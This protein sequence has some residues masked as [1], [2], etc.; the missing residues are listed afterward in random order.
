MN[1]KP[2]QL[3]QNGYVLLDSLEHKAL[4]PFIQIY[5]KKKTFAVIF[6]WAAN[7]LIFLIILLRLY[8]FYQPEKFKFGDAIGHLSY[9]FA[10]AFC[11]IPIHEYIHVLAYKS[12][13]AKTTSY[14]VNLKKFYFMAIADKFVANRKEFTVVALAPFVLI[15]FAFLIVFLC[16]EP[17]WTFTILGILFTHTACCSG[18]FG[19]LS[20]FEFYKHK[21]IVT[22]DDKENGI[23]YFYELPE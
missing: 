9:G 14:D 22:Y 15:S 5:L 16:V 3:Q 19:L 17:L 18:D 20:Y 13:G 23:S 12:Q 4:I 1:L 2:N 8:Q 11:L 7:M 6:Y 21:K 10:L